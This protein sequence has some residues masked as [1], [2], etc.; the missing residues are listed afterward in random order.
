MYYFIVSKE[1]ISVEFSNLRVTVGMFGSQLKNSSIAN[2][3]A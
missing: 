1:R 2:I 3:S